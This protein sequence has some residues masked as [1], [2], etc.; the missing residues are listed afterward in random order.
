MELTVVLDRVY[1]EII[2]SNAQ[3][4]IIAF[5]FDDARVLTDKKELRILRL[6]ALH[7]GEKMINVNSIRDCVA[8][9]RDQGK[10]YYLLLQYCIYFNHYT[11]NA[12]YEVF[13]ELR[14]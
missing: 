13:P 4:P 1:N 9:L 14:K 2:G 6:N 7:N 11:Y 3:V 8:M 5:S 12:I 10:N